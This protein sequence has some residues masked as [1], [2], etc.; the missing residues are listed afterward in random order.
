MALGHK[1]GAV[2]IR[3]GPKPSQTPYS[4]G[5]PTLSTLASVLMALGHNPHLGM[6]EDDP[7]PPQTPYNSGIPCI[8]GPRP[9]DWYCGGIVHMLNE[10]HDYIFKTD[11]AANV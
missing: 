7:R 6:I 3:E 1:P 4:Y 11:S 5:M 8:D 10:F 9:Q 2:V